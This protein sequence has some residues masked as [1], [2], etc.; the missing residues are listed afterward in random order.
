MKVIRFYAR[1]ALEILSVEML[2]LVLVGA[3]NLVWK[4]GGLLTGCVAA[5]P[6][7]FSW[8]AAAVMMQL[9]EVYA[10]LVLSFGATRRQITVALVFWWFATA[11]LAALQASLFRPLI[12]F[13]NLTEGNDF[14]TAIYQAPAL[15]WFF[16]TLLANSVLMLSV[17]LPPRGWGLAGRVIL[18]G[19]VLFGE[20]MLPIAN[21]ILGWPFQA[22]VL[23]GV[24]GGTL[25]VASLLKIQ[26][27]DAE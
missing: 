4:G 9:S 7:V 10:R 1:P 2:A 24:L 23:C 16:L 8:S 5:A 15:S 6:V 22:G 14:I 25:L 18:N 11:G 21:H 3:V 13:L 19:L 20:L 27:L 17:F 26:W 12:A